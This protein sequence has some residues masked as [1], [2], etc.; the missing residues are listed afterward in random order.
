[1]INLI[2]GLAV[3]AQAMLLGF[4]VFV[5]LDIRKENKNED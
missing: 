4:G 5:W 2:V 3:F 1:M